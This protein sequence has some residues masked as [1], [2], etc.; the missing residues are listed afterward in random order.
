MSSSLTICL[1]LVQRQVCCLI[2]KMQRTEITRAAYS[3]PIPASLIKGGN[4]K[5]WVKFAAVESVNMT[6]S[7]NKSSTPELLIVSP[8]AKFQ[9][10]MPAP[11]MEQNTY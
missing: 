10:T 11:K 2:Q 8:T 5:N 4:T 1:Q 9:L 3:L 6:Q 7:L